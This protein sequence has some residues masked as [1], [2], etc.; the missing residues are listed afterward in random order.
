MGYFFDPIVVLHVLKNLE[1]AP[2]NSGTVHAAFKDRPDIPEG[3][4][5]LYLD[6]LQDRELVEEDD[7]RFVITT[8]GRIL[9]REVE[10]HVLSEDDSNG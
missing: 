1:M 6:F 10:I 9:L 3:I 7:D 5:T 2:E 8:K 4:Q